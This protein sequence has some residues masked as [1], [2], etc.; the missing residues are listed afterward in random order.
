MRA[1]LRHHSELSVASAG[2]YLVG[3]VLAL[4][5]VTVFQDERSRLHS[6]SLVVSGISFTAA[7]VFLV[8][9]RRT[10]TRPAL[11][12]MCVSAALVLVMVF[13]APSEIRAMNSALLFYTFIIYLV[14]FGP[15]W[16]ARSFGVVWLAVYCTVL[17]VRFGPE[18]HPFLVSLVLTAVLLGELV[19]AYKNRLE[20][21]SLTDPLCGVWNKRGFALLT[22]R[23]VLALRRTGKPLS[24]LY[25][26]IDDL[27]RVNDELGH[28]E[29]DRLLREFAAE[30]DRA[31]RAQDIV[32]RLGG[33]EFA[34]L[35]PG[36][37]AEQA[38]ATG[39]RLTRVLRETSWSFGVA[40]LDPGE[41]PDVFIARADRLMLEQKRRRKAERE[42][43]AE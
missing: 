18:V 9:G 21:N 37:D 19:G 24:V 10:A 29:G 14:W 16:L 3:G 20:E 2:F 27:K 15:M 6:V 28:A 39:R 38:A 30:L 40:T 4:L 43:V 23:T 5:L 11:V 31:T 36:V 41:H 12:L 26:D 42:G 33:D 35:M 7:A 8:L 32:A 13:F 1:A 34:L 17:A 25:V 22:E